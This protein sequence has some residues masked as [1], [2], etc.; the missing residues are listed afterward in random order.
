MCLTTVTLVS[1]AQSS[2]PPLFCEFFKAKSNKDQQRCPVN[3]TQ[4]WSGWRKIRH[5]PGW[6]QSAAAATT[7]DVAQSKGVSPSQ[8]V[9]ADIAIQIQGVDMIKQWIARYPT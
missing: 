5:G 8:R 6:S 7:F 9:V 1:W 4:V 3:K 2:R